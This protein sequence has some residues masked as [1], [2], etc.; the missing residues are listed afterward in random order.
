MSQYLWQVLPPAPPEFLSRASGLH[1]LLLHLLYNRGMR[2]P[3]QGKSF[4][5]ADERLCYD[6]W[7]LPEM[8]QAVNRL[9][10]ALL[11][12]E[13][14][15]VYGDYDT[16]GITATALL[17]QGLEA[18]GANTIP[19]IPNRLQGHGLHPPALASLFQQGATLVITADCGTTCYQEVAE[20]QK[21]GQDII[22]TDHH[23]CPPQLPPALATVKPKRPDSPSPYPE[24]A[25]G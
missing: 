3:A 22:I 6:P 11:S 12:G 13:K 24:L 2:D 4:L 16:D 20:A 19:Y 17:V 18:V 7:L 9:C 8:G 14:I 25:G 10:R 1:P 15:A 21:R 23:T 5:A